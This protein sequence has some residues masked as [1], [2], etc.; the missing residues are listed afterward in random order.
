VD[1][2]T[3]VVVLF[4]TGF[5]LPADAV[6]L[7]FLVPRSFARIE[8]SEAFLF[9]APSTMSAG[10]SPGLVL[11]LLGSICVDCVVGFENAASEG[12]FLFQLVHFNMIECGLVYCIACNVTHTPGPI[13]LLHCLTVMG[14]RFEE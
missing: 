7:A 9:R 3:V 11:V 2:T 14:N 6:A 4:V 1:F 5:F 10:F 12:F 8:R 13:V